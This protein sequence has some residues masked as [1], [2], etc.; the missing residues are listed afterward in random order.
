M[1]E[2]KNLALHPFGLVVCKSGRCLEEMQGATR[3]QKGRRNARTK[4]VCRYRG[5]QAAV[6]VDFGSV[7]SHHLPFGSGTFGSNSEL[8]WTARYTRKSP[9]G[10]MSVK[11]FIALPG[12]HI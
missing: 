11:S 8:K 5:S 4:V 2:A 12:Y 6:K 9:V 1:G 10:Y 3:Y 7:F